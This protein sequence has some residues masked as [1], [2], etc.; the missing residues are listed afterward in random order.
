MTMSKPISFFLTT[1]FAFVLVGCAQAV[2]TATVT[3]L[4]SPTPTPADPLVLLLAPP[5]SDASLV[6]VASELASAYA[7]GAGMQFEQRSLLNPAELPASLAKLIVL[8][9]DPG[10]ATL[11]AAA[12]QAQVIALGFS[13][14]GSIANLISLPLGSGQDAQIAFIAGYISAM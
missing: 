6:A 14:E 9:P 1:F 8:A 10:A 2:P 5:E 11:A 3:A 7:S 4:P 12:P 13:S